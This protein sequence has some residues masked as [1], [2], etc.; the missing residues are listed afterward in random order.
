MLQHVAMCPN[1][2]A[3]LMLLISACDI[4]YCG[5]T[6][7]D[8]CVTIMISRIKVLQNHNIPNYRTN[9]S[10]APNPNIRNMTIKLLAN[11]P[12][13]LAIIFNAPAILGR[14]ANSQIPAKFVNVYINRLLLHTHTHA[15]TRTIV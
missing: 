11:L 2:M 4:F 1:T 12:A 14:G 5:C 7:N 13:V 15:C 9:F 8:L 3:V 6:C 10:I